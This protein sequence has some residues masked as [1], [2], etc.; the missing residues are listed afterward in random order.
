MPG[1]VFCSYSSSPM[2]LHLR[3]VNRSDEAINGHVRVMQR[4]TIVG[5]HPWLTARRGTEKHAR[6]ALERPTMDLAAKTS[7]DLV[8]SL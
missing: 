3:L 1:L 7:N 4:A 8:R 6:Q 2:D 5:K